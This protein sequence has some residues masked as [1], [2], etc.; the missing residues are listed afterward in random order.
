V[1]SDDEL[2]SSEEE[3]EEEAGKEGEAQQHTHTSEY[4]NVHYWRHYWRYKIYNSTWEK[5]RIYGGPFDTEVAAYQAYVA[6]CKELG[7]E[8]NTVKR[9]PYVAHKGKTQ[10]ERDINRS[11][12]RN[13]KANDDGD[14]ALLE[15]SPG[16][17]CACTGVLPSGAK[18]RYH[19]W[20]ISM[21]ITYVLRY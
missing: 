20:H 16:T 7:M 11:R 3:E 19:L 5:Q 10:A 12:A 9:R 4:P 21:R 18:C 17:N 8:P 15:H 6:K 13:E 14:T 2:S 1:E